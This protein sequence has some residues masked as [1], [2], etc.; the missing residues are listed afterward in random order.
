MTIPILTRSYSIYDPQWRPQHFF[1]PGA[2]EWRITQSPR[3]FSYTR[4]RARANRPRRLANDY[5]FHPSPFYRAVT[6][7]YDGLDEHLFP[8]PLPYDDTDIDMPF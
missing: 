3:R 5:Y 7:W 6:K 4:A 2:I 1:Y 8:R